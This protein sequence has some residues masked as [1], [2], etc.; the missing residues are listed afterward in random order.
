MARSA[1]KARFALA[2]LT[3]SLLHHAEGAAMTFDGV[4]GPEEA[5]GFA[6]GA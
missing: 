2:A 1:I 6:G 4:E 3:A 5:L